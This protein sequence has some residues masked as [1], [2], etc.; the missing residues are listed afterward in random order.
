VT[1]GRGR[2]LLRRG[3]AVLAVVVALHGVA[4]LLGLQVAW[5]FDVVVNLGGAID[6]GGMRAPDDG[7][8]R[9]VVLQHGLFRTAASLGRLERTLRAAGYEVLNPG[10][11]ST[12]EPIEAHAARLGAAIAARAGQGPVDE[13]SFVG[14]SM[15]GLVIQEYLRQPGHV[16]PRACVY[17]ATPHRGAILA[18]LRKHWFVFRW[19]MGTTAALQLSPGDPIHQ[20]SIPYGDR[21]GTVVGT[22]GLF[23]MGNR[24]IPGDDDGTVAVAEATFPG[25]A[26]SVRLPYGHTRI[27]VVEAVH[28][29]VL[30]FLAHRAFAPVAG[31]Q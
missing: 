12:T 16:E 20:R 30:H 5:P 10:Y 15:G 17:L 24:S 1:Q 19:A 4:I 27:T 23:G 14:H 3:L 29:Q 26:S 28:A 31:R 8:V 2:G 9:V 11:R 25:A 7:R 22:T 18:D 13:W 21:S 6:P